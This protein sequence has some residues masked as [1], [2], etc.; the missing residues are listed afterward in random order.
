MGDTNFLDRCGQQ[1]LYNFGKKI[2]DCDWWFLELFIYQIIF[3]INSDLFFLCRVSKIHGLTVVRQ[4]KNFMTLRKILRFALFL[5]QNYKTKVLT[6]Q[7]I[8]FQN[9]CSRVYWFCLNFCDGLVLEVVI[10]NFCSSNICKNQKGCN[11]GLKIS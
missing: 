7:K 10:N 8:Y 2:L 11:M 3:L 9:V 6:A 4:R 5:A 1:D